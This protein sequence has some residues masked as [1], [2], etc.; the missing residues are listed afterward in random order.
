MI[1][2]EKED[3]LYQAYQMSVIHL[4]RMQFAFGKIQHFFPLNIE[5]YQSITPEEMSFFDQFI[6]RFTKLQDVIGA[7]LFSSVLINLG[8]DIYNKPFI[9]IVQKLEKINAL[10]SADDWF[11]LREVRNLLTHEY[12]FNQ[13]EI[14]N[15]LNLLYSNFNQLLDMWSHLDEF[16][17]HR[18]SYLLR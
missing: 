10:K 6:Y 9:D 8:E 2:F 11:M 7:K 13:Q 16:I 5:K 3:K 17:K 4:E 14:I 12:P 15:D 1:V 18:L